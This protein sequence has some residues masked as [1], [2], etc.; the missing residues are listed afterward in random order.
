MRKLIILVLTVLL[1]IP[2]GAQAQGA[3]HFNELVIEIWPEYDRPGVL[4]IYRGFLASDQSLPAEVTFQIPAEVGQP[5]AVAVRDPDGQLISV[6]YDRVVRGEVAE[7]TFTA[8]SQEIQFEYYDPGLQL[9]GDQRSYQYQW[10][11]RH[12]VDA[13]VIQAQQP[14]GAD[15]LKITPALGNSFAGSDGLTYFYR[16]FEPLEQEPLTIRMEYTKPDDSL[17][18]EQQ[19]VQPSQ[20]IQANPTFSFQGRSLLP[21]ILGGLGLGLL[22][23]AAVLFWG[24]DSGNPLAD[25]FTALFSGRRGDSAGGYCPQCG[26][27]RGKEDRFCRQCGHQ[28]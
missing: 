12:Q 23:A 15:N 11:G 10:P 9:E 19:D 25:R 8:S 14:R 3:L 26:S 24:F 27:P 4:I 28:F 17:S 5:N 6:Q 7:V 20:P 16:Q 18:I 2:F 13:A 21:W 22:L 1:L